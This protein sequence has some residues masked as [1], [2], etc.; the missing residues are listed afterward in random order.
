MAS[1]FRI[2]MLPAAHGD[3][4]WVE[5]GDPE[6]PRRIVIDG[7]PAPSYEVGLRR[8][9]L[10][11]AAQGRGKVAIDLL[12]VTHVDTDHIDG[13]I[14]LLREP[15]TAPVEIAEVWFNAWDQLARVGGDDFQPMQ[16]EFFGALLAGNRALDEVWNR[17]TDRRAIVVP[18]EGPLPSFELPDRARLTLLSPGEKQLRRLRA[19]WSA[20]IR[21]FS[22][23]DTGEAIRRLETRREYRPPAAPPVFGGK[24]LGDDRSAPNGSSIAFLLEY[25]GKSCLF[26]GDAHAR[27]LASSLRRLVQERKPGTTGP[28]RVDAVKLPHHGSMSNVD[29]DLLTVLESPR[30]LISTNGAIFNHPDVETAHLVSLRSPEPPELLCN[31]QTP[32]TARLAGGGS[33]AARWRVR[34]PESGAGGIHLDLLGPPTPRRPRPPAR[35]PPAPRRTRP[36]GAA[37]R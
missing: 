11:A 27:V 34:Y 10:D 20:A 8:R 3:A 12:V 15:E 9:L 2:E 30:W 35:K 25:E 26:A 16:G 14:I 31:Y 18:D 37:R 22:P 21:E 4:L 7:G 32:A 28:L 23:G 6:R 5:Y 24:S 17:R 29:E 33:G 19:R 1:V 36:T 13:P